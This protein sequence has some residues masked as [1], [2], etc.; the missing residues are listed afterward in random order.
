MPDAE[1]MKQGRAADAESSPSVDETTGQPVEEAEDNLSRFST[2]DSSPAVAEQ[3]R[4]TEKGDDDQP[5][6]GSALREKNE[7]R[8]Q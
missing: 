8:E 5:L 1:K 7:G 4:T 2:K 6:S 3:G